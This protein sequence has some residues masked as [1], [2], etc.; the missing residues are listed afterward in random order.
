[1]APPEESQRLRDGHEA[2]KVVRHGGEDSTK[3]C[4]A[5]QLMLLAC[6]V[7][8]LCQGGSV[9]PASRPLTIGTKYYD[10]LW[11]SCLL[12][13]INFH[14]SP[15]NMQEYNDGYADRRTSNL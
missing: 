11:Q 3:S 13:I 12:Q 5:G 15:G 2:L 10:S 14:S 6:G 4:G 7:E 1:M 8:A 9:S